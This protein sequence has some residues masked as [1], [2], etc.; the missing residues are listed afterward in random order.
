M[1][2]IVIPFKS[3]EGELFVLLQ[4]RIVM[5]EGDID[6]NSAA[7]SFSIPV[8]GSSIRGCYSVADQKAEIRINHKPFFVTCEMIKNYILNKVL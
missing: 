4:K 6:G 7:A 5:A 2:Q 8:L 1:C 3:T